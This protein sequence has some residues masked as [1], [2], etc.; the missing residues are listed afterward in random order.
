MIPILIGPQERKAM[1]AVK[2]FAE[3]EENRNDLMAV[4]EGRRSPPGLDERYCF[5]LPAV[6]P[7]LRWKCVYSIDIGGPM[8]LTK[9]FSMSIEGNHDRVPNP[10]A[11]QMIADELEMG[12]ADLMML[13]LPEIGEE[14]VAHYM[15]AID[16]AGKEAIEKMKAEAKEATP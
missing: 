9:H 2:E 1:L 15:V 3:K 11:V 8:I 4:M 5:Y 16:P 14:R 13:G 6:W 10:H 7:G 12:P